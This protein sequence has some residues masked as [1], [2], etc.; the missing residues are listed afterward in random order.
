MERK[1]DLAP[2]VTPAIEC[3]ST[4]IR[5]IRL[6]LASDDIGISQIA[7]RQDAIDLIQ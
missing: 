1:R 2:E 6:G 5:A 4:C 7:R 3:E